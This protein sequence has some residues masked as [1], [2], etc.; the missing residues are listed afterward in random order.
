M[1]NNIYCHVMYVASYIFTSVLF[2]I[3]LLLYI[4]GYKLKQDQKN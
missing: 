1:D 4:N 2:I 3:F